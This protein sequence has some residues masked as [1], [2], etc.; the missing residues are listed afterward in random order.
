MDIPRFL[1]PLDGPALAAAGIPGG[2][3]FGMADRVRF[4]EIDAL[5]HVNHTAYLRWFESLRVHYARDYG[6]TA[7]DGTG[8]QVV[9]KG[10]EAAYHAP[11]FLDEDYIVTARTVSFR[12]T[13]FRMHY[14]V[15]APEIRVEG[16]A[17]VV[18]LGPDGTGRTPLDDAVK[19]RFT[20]R[21]GAVDEG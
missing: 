12:R 3:P 8:P 6:V 17:L 11:M 13:S 2:W 5:D 1:V 14:A 15:F 7:Y 16:W 9:L 20:E 19:A 10:L 21:D 4:S 18:L